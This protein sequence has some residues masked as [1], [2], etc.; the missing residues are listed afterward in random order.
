MPRFLTLILVFCAPL[1]M[2]AQTTVKNVSLEEAFMMARERNLSL[3]IAREGIATAKAEKKEFNALW[4]PMLAVTG[5]YSHSLTEIAA[6]TTVGEIGSEI[7]GSIAPEVSG[8]PVIKELIDGIGNSELRFPIVPRNTT[9]VGVEL[10]WVVYSGGRRVMASRIADRVLSVAKEQYNATENGIM[11][12]VAEAYW[13]LALARQLTDVRRSALELYSEHLRQA[14]RLEEEGMINRAERLVAEVAC[15]QSITL[16]ASAESEQQA[17][18][19]ALATLLAEDSLTIVP[20]TSLAVPHTIPAK[21]EFIAQI[22]TTPTMNMLKSGE[23]IASLTLRSE[24]SRYQPTISLIGHQQLWSSGLDKNIF[25]RTMVGIG[26]SWTLFDGL[27]REGAVARSKSSLRAAQTTYRKTFRDLHASIDKCY[28]VLT[29]SLNE[30]QARQT[31]LALAEELHRTQLRAFAEGMATSADVVDATLRLSEVQLAQLATL[32]AID[33]SLA[34][35]L[36]LV[37]RADCLTTYFTHR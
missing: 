22:M 18:A 20:T 25:P 8:N 2:P 28:G 4:Y 9:E 7:L 17:A 12:A 32:Y 27:A 5:E 21:E 16:L 36:M 1:C 35:L 31:T 30:Y 6:V 10:A 24:R 37:G 11:T 13:G 23:E 3:V 15:K 19:E 33:T 26:L 14:R 34:T 29:T